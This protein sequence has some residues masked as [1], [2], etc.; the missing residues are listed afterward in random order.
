MQHKKYSKTQKILQ[1]MKDV[2]EVYPDIKVCEFSIYL[3][4][5]DLQ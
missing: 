1:L 5:W 3:K 4:I 2:L